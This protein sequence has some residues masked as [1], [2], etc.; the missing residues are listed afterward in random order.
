[1]K[2]LLAVIV[3]IAFTGVLMKAS[4]EPNTNAA[5]EFAVQIIISNEHLKSDDKKFKGVTDIHEEICEGP[6]KYKYTT[7]HTKNYR[8]ASELKQKMVDAGF[9]GAFV[10]PYIDG[11]RNLRGG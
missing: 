11:K 6:Y 7:G 9:T 2:L 1:M 3:S 4:S 5:K 8:E 10:V